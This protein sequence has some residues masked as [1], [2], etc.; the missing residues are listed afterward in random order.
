M[1]NLVKEG[2]LSKIGNDTYAI[3]KDKVYFFL[4]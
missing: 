4:S 2:E 1:D 3:K